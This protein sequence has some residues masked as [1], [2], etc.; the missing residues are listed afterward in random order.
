MGRFSPIHR[1][2][3]CKCFSDKEMKGNDRNLFFSSD[4][5]GF[6]FFKNSYKVLFL[7]KSSVRW[8]KYLLMHLPTEICGEEQ[9]I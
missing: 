4:L 9:P 8:K 3:G 6:F 2:P 5:E 1:R 7:Q